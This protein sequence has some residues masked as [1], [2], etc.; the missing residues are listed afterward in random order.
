MIKIINGK[1]YNT[2]TAEKVASYGYGYVGDF[3]HYEEELYLTP[4]GSWF[5]VGE[6]GAMSKYAESMCDGGRCGGEGAF[7]LSPNDALA[8]LEAHEEIDAIET[9]FG[10]TIEDA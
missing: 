10:S 2:E 9:H 3:K 8:W 6:G 4:K 1:R 5:L 7:V